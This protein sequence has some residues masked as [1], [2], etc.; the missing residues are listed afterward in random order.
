[1]AKLYL[2]FKAYTEICY[3]QIRLADESLSNNKSTDA[4]TEQKLNEPSWNGL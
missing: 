4:E 3:A 2:I 1:M